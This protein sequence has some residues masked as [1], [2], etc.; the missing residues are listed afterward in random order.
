MHLNLYLD[1]KIIDKMKKNMKIHGFSD[2]NDYIKYLI[3]IDK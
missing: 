2:I 3:T 1:S